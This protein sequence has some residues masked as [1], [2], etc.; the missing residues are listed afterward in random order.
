MRYFTPL[1]HRLVI[2]VVVIIIIIIICTNVFYN[3]EL[4]QRVENIT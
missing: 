4:F 1:T 3:R 2:N